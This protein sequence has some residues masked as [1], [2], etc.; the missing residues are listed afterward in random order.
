MASL[1]GVAG[2]VLSGRLSRR[3]GSARIIWF[4]MLVLGLPQLLV[5]LAEPG[6]RIAVF[7]IGLAVFW[8]SAVVY[9]VAQVSYRQ[10][11][12]PPRLLGRMNAAV[13]WVVWGTLPLGGAARRR[14]RHLLGVRPTLWIAFAGSWAAGWWVFFSPLRRLRD[15]PRP[16]GDDP[17]SLTGHQGA[18]SQ[19]RAAE[20]CRTAPGRSSVTSP[21][22]ASA[23]SVV[24][25]R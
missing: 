5:P 12:C 18:G 3:I 24:P 22:A 4:S 19:A 15:V 20:S 11:I 1:G 13:R 16:Q 6:W 25:P 9:N 10:A 23:P 8:F 14:A 2:G 21:A 17:R 7:V